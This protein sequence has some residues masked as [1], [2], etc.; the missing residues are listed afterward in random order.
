MKCQY[1]F[2][3]L[4]LLL[5]SCGKD[6]DFNDENKKATLSV[7]SLYT[8]RGGKPE[9]PDS[10]AKVFVFYDRVAEDFLNCDIHKDGTVTKKGVL[11]MT[12]DIKGVTNNNGKVVFDIDKKDSFYMVFVMSN[13]CDGKIM[14]NFQHDSSKSP[15]MTFLFYLD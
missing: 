14:G 11:V 7:N 2:L 13:K 10:N 9:K 3:L 6:K 1:C 4:L 12:A 8:Q 15:E 5:M